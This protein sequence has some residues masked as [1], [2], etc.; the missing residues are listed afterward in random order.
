M[1]N[2]IKVEETMTL[3]LFFNDWLEKYANDEQNLSPDTRQNY[4]NIL[5]KRIL[6]KYGHMKLTDIKT[7]HIV[8]FVNDLKKDGKRLDGKK[9]PLSP[10]SI[11]NCYRAVQ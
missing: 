10:S 9:G 5:K 1:D 6:P 2:N 3:N 11:A 8:N 4:V 7:I